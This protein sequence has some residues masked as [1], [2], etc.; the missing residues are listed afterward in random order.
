M[1]GDYDDEEI[2]DIRGVSFRQLMARA[3]GA[4][5]SRRQPSRRRPPARRSA[6]V[7]RRT[8]GYLKTRPRAG[9]G[10]EFPL[11]F[12]SAQFGENGP[13]TLIL[14][15][16]PQRRGKPNRL[17]TIA[18]FGGGAGGLLTI[19]DIKVGTLSQLVSNQS[20]PFGMFA[21]DAV[22]T[23]LEIAEVG[24]GIQAAISVTLSG[25]LGVGETVDI[26]AAVI[27]DVLD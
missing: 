18:A 20:I 27:C 21:P 14:I 26:T 11:G 5:T 3:R 12:G 16:E 17:T 22:G 6:I 10:A 2:E 23:E 7:A 25:S 13:T 15:A 4:A 8:P 24:P 19:A 9:A 1:D